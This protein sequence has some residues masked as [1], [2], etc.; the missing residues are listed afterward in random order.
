MILAILLAAALGWWLHKE[1]ALLPNLKRLAILGGGGILIAR[2]LETGQVL[3]AG[4]AGAGL[5][6]WWFASRR[7]A[8][9]LAPGA[10][11]EARA[12]LGVAPTDDA[13]AINA[14]WRRVIAQ[15]H[16]DKGG[17]ADLARRVTAARD[18]L[19]ARR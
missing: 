5:A 9:A 10:L 11:A 4:V 18:L 19:L 16:P 12:V 17:T 14:A 2:L 1:G 7:N 3:F 6:A 8:A 13:A 15:V